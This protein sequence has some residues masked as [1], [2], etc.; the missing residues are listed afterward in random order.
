MSTES[1]TIREDRLVFPEGTSVDDQIENRLKRRF[2]RG[3]FVQESLETPDENLVIK[4]GTSYPKDVSDRR[5]RDN[6]MKFINLGDV[7]TLYAEPTGEGY[8][9]V[10]LPDR[11][12]LKNSAQERRSEIIGQLDWSTAKAI[13]DDVYQLNPVRNQLNSLIQIIRWLH[14]EPEL[15]VERVDDI[16]RTDNSREYL[17]VMHDL[18]FVNLDEENDIVKPGGKM[19]GAEAKVIED[20][21]LDE[22]DFEKVVIGH[23]IK[24]GY[25]V[26]RDQLDLRMLNHFPKYANS[27]Y[28]TALQRGTHEVHLDNTALIENLSREW[29]EDVDPLQLE[30]KLNKLE[31]VGVI[32]REGEYVTGKEDVYTSISQDTA[33]GR[34]AD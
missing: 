13:Y 11:S 1:I 4:L 19:E 3:V 7:E 23:L 33:T 21:N 12:E 17:R 10:E 25:N 27:F 14:R 29:G 20:E 32:E 22:D 5:E 30:D 31:E 2:G 24:D 34:V 26:L 8:Y 9:T 28:Y 18:G 6:V 16:Q 15:S